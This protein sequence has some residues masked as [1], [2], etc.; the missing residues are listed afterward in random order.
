MIAGGISV[1]KCRPAKKEV[2][3]KREE[4]E[5]QNVGIVVYPN[6]VR[7]GAQL[8]ISLSSEVEGL[9][10][11]L[12]SSSGALISALQGNSFKGNTV[13]LS[14][15]PFVIPGMYFLRVMTETNKEQTTKIII[16]K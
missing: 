1:M 11:K 3:V 12:L 16:A 4:Q 2:P 15:P 6:P 14:V 9:H 7:P 8:T 5:K 13:T 10:V